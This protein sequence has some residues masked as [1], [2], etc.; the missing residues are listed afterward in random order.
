MG[1]G[2]K[3]GIGFLVVLLLLCVI[4]GSIYSYINGIRNEGIKREN[5]LTAQYL[6]NQNEL[7]TYISGF[8]ELVGVAQAG[9]DALDQVLEDA[10]KGRYDEDGFGS[11]SPLFTAISEAYPDLTGLTELWGKIQDYIS[12]GREAYKNI[13]NKLLDMLQSY[14]T[15]RETGFLKSTIVNMFGFPSSRLKATV[16]DQTWTG[17]QAL[18][19]MY[20]I[21]LTSK[22]QEAYESGTLDPLTVPTAAP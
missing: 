3:V 21:V 11:G 9:T 6:S 20:Q 17:P 4:G 16:G 14:D 2:K 19:K 10:V 15:W 22:A 12:A 1:L 13:Q 5:Q 7:S 8:Y 18:D